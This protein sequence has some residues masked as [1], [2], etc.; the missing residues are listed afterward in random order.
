MKKKARNFFTGFFATM[1]LLAVFAGG[2]IAS[3]ISVEVSESRLFG[4]ID[5]VNG[6]AGMHGISPGLPGLVAYDHAGGDWTDMMLN[7]FACP[8][9]WLS[10]GYE[11][12]SDFETIHFATMRIEMARADYNYPGTADPRIT[13]NNA[14]P[15]SGDVEGIR[16]GDLVNEGN[17][18]AL[19]VYEIDLM[20]WTDRLT[21]EYIYFSL[22]FNFDENGR[23]E[24]FIFGGQAVVDYIQID[25]FGTK[26]FD[27]GTGGGGDPT[28]PVPE[29][30]TMLLFGTGLVGLVVCS[31]RKRKTQK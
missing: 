24:S 22:G 23:N 10:F 27:D 4:D 21:R 31:R 7:T 30:A 14:A 29:P 8:I 20:A 19:N 15:G 12:F 11:G 3:L 1:F 18:P 25:V 17:S 28:A 26:M 16:I 9:N 5:Q 2:A 13:I 6:H